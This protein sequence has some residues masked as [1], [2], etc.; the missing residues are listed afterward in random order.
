MLSMMPYRE[1]SGRPPEPA[2]AAARQDDTAVVIRGLLLDFYGTVVEEDDEIVASICA[3]AAAS[4]AGTV[5]AE[6][7]GAA[8]WQEFQA[9]MRGR[10]VP[11]ATRDCRSQPGHGAER[12]RV[13]CECGCVVRRAGPVLANGSM[14][15]IR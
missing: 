4:G 6:Q 3:R 1:R 2:R 5:T 13:C 10:C 14:W 9:A 11:V 15:E 8:W 7:I 12:N